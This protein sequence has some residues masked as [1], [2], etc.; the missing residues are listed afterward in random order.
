MRHNSSIIL[1]GV[2]DIIITI[3]EDD[4]V[5]FSTPFYVRIGKIKYVEKLLVKE[6]FMCKPNNY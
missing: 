6:S 2:T 3:K 4:D 1:S 5:Y